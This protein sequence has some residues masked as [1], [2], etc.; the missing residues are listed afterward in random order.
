MQADNSPQGQ[1]IRSKLETGVAKVGIYGML[2][3]IEQGVDR[4]GAKLDVAVKRMRKFIRDTD[5]RRNRAGASSSSP[6][7]FCLCFSLSS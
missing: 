7:F 1:T 2:N 4:S 6:L 3:D 5:S